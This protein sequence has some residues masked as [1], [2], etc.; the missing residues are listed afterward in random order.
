M[1]FIFDK[2][3]NLK[4]SNSQN[5]DALNTSTYA[6]RLIYCIEKAPKN[7]SFTVGLF[8]EW[9]SGK[10]SVIKTMQDTYPP[11]VK[12]EEKNVKV[13][14]YDAW[15][16]SGDSF[17]R[18]FLLELQQQLGV[19]TSEKMQ[20]F[21]DNINED[22]E[23]KHVTNNNY[24]Y[25]ILIVLFVLC[26]LFIFGNDVGAEW[27]LGLTTF[28][29]MS[30]LLM[31]LKKNSTD[32]LKVTVQKS[33]LFAP[34]QFE[35]CFDDILYAAFHHHAVSEKTLSWIKN[36]GY[37]IDLDQLVVVID[38]ID[39][40]QSD[41]AYNLLTDIKN[42][43]DKEYNLVF[44][45]PVDVD[46]LRKHILNSSKLSKDELNQDADEFLRKFF[47]VSI[48]MKP[49]RSDEI[50]EFA[51]KLNVNNNLGFNETT[52]NLVSK[53]FATNP[54]RIIQ[55]FN[56]L[57]VELQGYDEKMRVDDQ[58]LITKVQIIKE[59]FPDFYQLVLSEPRLLY[60]D[61][62]SILNV[63]SKEEKK[64][65]ETMVLEYKRLFV[66]LTNTLAVSTPYINK[67]NIIS[68]V[69]SNSVTFDG[70]PMGMTEAIDINDYESIKAAGGLDK[71]KPQL[72]KYLQL[73]LT[74][75]L[76]RNL[77]QT[78]V[79]TYLSTYLNLYNDNLLKDYDKKELMNI[80]GH[81]D[82]LKQVVSNIPQ[83]EVL[84]ALGKDVERLSL[85]KL[86][87][88]IIDYL[89]IPE[90]T[91]VKLSD[92]SRNAILYGCT[93]WDARQAKK[94]AKEFA[95]AYMENPLEAQKY[96]YKKNYSVL[97]TN[98]L[99][100]EN[101][102]AI[103]KESMLEKTSAYQNVRYFSEHKSFSESLFNKFA[104]KISELSI[105]YE[106]KGNNAVS[107]LPYIK[108][109]YPVIGNCLSGLKVTDASGIANLWTS[110]SGRTQVSNRERSL[111]LDNSGNREVI[112]QVLELFYVITSISQRQIVPAD[113]ISNI[114]SHEEN[115]GILLLKLYD[116]YKNGFDVSHYSD[117][118]C[119]TDKLDATHL[120][121]LDAMF[122]CQDADIVPDS[123]KI[124]QLDHLVAL[125]VDGIHENI[126]AISS[127]IDELAMVEELEFIFEN[128]LKNKSTDEL[129]KL[130]PKLQRF[131]VAKFVVDIEN[132]KNNETVLKSIAAYG[133]PTEISALVP[134]IN[135]KLVNS[136]KL[137]SDSL[138]MIT[139]VILS[140]RSLKKQEIEQIRVNLKGI[141]GSKLP[142]ETIKECIEHI[143][144]LS[145]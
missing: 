26:I 126:K 81:E 41:V 71:Y 114:M 2:E 74:R 15:K 113:E 69:L 44:V 19:K 82:S 7:R 95:Q 104:K 129:S 80:I 43:L 24:I 90:D 97:I 66:F 17:R 119:H 112:D 38:N 52:L 45:V 123:R 117:A 127:M 143:E 1:N 83:L 14:N 125:I 53:Q 88:S 140:L 77:Y 100:E 29:T 3:I 108:E 137:D 42:F 94:L 79:L 110:I 121:M 73:Q 6:D 111:I 55:L 124:S 84:I 58:S 115:H 39:R 86:S 47:N 13:V 35:D 18:M 36:E 4:H 128:V 76:Q 75:A 23:I 106:W 133:K 11:K 57:T 64:V 25:L 60:K 72:I 28:I 144:S 62:K 118:L 131:A 78:D 33:R 59:E 54:R 107:L 21:Y 102:S 31:S 120:E 46:A 8:G 87:N 63:Q 93:I 92:K 122:H 105:R 22:T 56:N 103:S 12:S 49:F 65:D 32:D 135:T 48:W 98:D 141:P 37:N 5:K 99:I 40:C 101:I 89:K 27:K 130:S 70:L 142:A 91:Q 134:I 68:K 30:T 136:N 138:Q 145:K 9:G 85:L 61:Y 10:S 51:S 34:E 96:D 139:R 50:F 132:Y 67:E 16:Y 109:L 20:R 116:L